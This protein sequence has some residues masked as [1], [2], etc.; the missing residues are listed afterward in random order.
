[1]NC[2]ECQQCMEAYLEGE[3]NEQAISAFE[4][5]LTSCET[6]RTEVKSVDKCINLMQTVLE[7]VN[8]PDTLRKGILEKLGCCDMGSVSNYE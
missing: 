3:L 4:K 2:K 8:P 5:H 6:C 7:D 1:M